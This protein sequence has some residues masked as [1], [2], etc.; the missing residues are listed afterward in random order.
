[1]TTQKVFARN[2]IKYRIDRQ[3]REELTA[4]MIP[5]MVPDAY[6]RSRI[7]S[8]YY[9]TPDRLL[10][11]RSL[12]GPVYKEKIRLRSYGLA[13]DDTT[14]FL[15]LKKK[16]RQVTYKR[17]IGLS[18]R[19]AED[20]LL[21]K[22]AV[23]TSQIARESDFTLKRYQ[24]L[25]PACLI[26]AEREAFYAKDDHEFRIT[27]DENLLADREHLS[28]REE[29]RGIPLTEKDEVLLEIKT[30]AAIP[31]WL[32][33]FL[34]ERKLNKASFSKYGTAYLTFL[35]DDRKTEKQSYTDERIFL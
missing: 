11:R 24:N 16:Y 7:L 23:G 35:S 18:L 8:L 17:R 5:Y 9:D 10:A 3:M 14:V 6:G 25:L 4:Y 2:E 27:F 19:D 33:R 28:L 32:C 29:A 20:C 12:E 21:G 13:R 1:M 30:D 22:R 34:S 15:E 26:S 31:L